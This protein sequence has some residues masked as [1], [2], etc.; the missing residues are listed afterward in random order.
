MPSV[1]LSRAS[2][3]SLGRFLEPFAVSAPKPPVSFPARFEPCGVAR[4][5]LQRSVASDPHAETSEELFGH[6]PPQGYRICP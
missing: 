4:L 2:T 6:G 1:D 3:A 5:V